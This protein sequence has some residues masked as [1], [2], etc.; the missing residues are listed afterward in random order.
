M[1]PREN[2]KMSEGL[3]FPWLCPAGPAGPASPAGVGLVALLETTLDVLRRESCWIL[4]ILISARTCS[5]RM[6]CLGVAMS[7]MELDENTLWVFAHRESAAE[8]VILETE[9]LNSATSWDYFK[10]MPA[11]MGVFDLTN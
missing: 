1:R 11:V 9:R 3:P 10:A 5:L 8:H 2:D 6:A 7:Q 4:S